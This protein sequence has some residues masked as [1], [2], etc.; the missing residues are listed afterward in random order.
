MRF[1]KGCKP[2]APDALGLGHATHLRFPRQAREAG[3]IVVPEVLD[4]GQ[5]GACTGNASALAIKVVGGLDELPS[6]LMLYYD[7]RAEEGDADEDAGAALA[8]VFDAAGRFGYCRESL[9]PYVPTLDGVTAR[10]SW[11]A[12]REGAANRLIKGAY[13]IPNDDGLV[14]AIMNAI[15]MGH[16]VV[17]GTSLDQA[18]EDLQAGQVWPGVRG[19]VIGGHAMILTAYRDYG[20]EMFTQ[21]S[22][23]A[24]FCEGG[25]AWVSAAAVRAGMDF[26]VPSVVRPW[27]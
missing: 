17:W 16:P 6:R 22:W 2:S 15:D 23:G 10:P 9:W 7:A 4:Q 1:A 20:A 13:R 26:W 18:F 3:A 11:A 19:P 8:E 24:N 27:A 12:Y 5:V 25:S 14:P 21:S